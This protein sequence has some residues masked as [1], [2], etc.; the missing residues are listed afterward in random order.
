MVCRYECG[1]L[2]YYNR[3]FDKVTVKN[4]VALQKFKRVFHKVTT[5]DDPYIE[6]VT[7]TLLSYVMLMVSAIS[8]CMIR[9]GIVNLSSQCYCLN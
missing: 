6:K 2:E 8:C 3:V 9:E 4:P 1:T 5:T 7:H